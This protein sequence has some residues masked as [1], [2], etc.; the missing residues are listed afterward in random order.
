MFV[1]SKDDADLNKIGN[2][3]TLANSVTAEDHG[4][5]HGYPSLAEDFPELDQIM[6]HKHGTYKVAWTTSVYHEKQIILYFINLAIT[7][8]EKTVKEELDNG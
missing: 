4:I 7:E 2:I 1:Q 6:K 3:H 5:M 8:A